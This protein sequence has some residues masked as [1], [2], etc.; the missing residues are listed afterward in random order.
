LLAVRA[1]SV[2]V[3]APARRTRPGEPLRLRVVVTNRLPLPLVGLTLDLGPVAGR[4]TLPPVRPWA[5]RVNLEAELRPAR[6]GVADLADAAVTCS[7]PF[8]LFVARQAAPSFGEVVVWPAASADVVPRPRACGEPLDAGHA[9]VQRPAAA[10]GDPAGVRAYAPGDA[11]RRIHWQATA[12]HDALMTRDRHATRAPAVWLAL[13]LDAAAATGD[14]DGADGNGANTDPGAAAAD[15]AAADDAAADDAAA[16]TA[17][18]DAACERAIERAAAAV[19]AWTCVGGRFGAEGAVAVGLILANQTIAPAAAAGPAHRARLLD[20][21]A[22]IDLTS[23]LARA[24]PAASALRASAV[25]IRAR[26]ESPA[27]TSRD[28]GRRVT[29]GGAELRASA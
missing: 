6:R 20:A 2:T 5:R 11:M 24:A 9:A 4:A 15:D 28:A 17:A 3:V 22:R 27:A 25:V 26:D 7:F 23:P 10:D 14:A 29:I 16:A 18:D 13:V 8:D 12:R 21:L 19:D 1:A